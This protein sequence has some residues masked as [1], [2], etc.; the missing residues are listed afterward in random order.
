M[1]KIKLGDRPKS[2]SKELSI[3]MLDGTTGSIKVDFTYRSR[4][5]YA[6]FVDEHYAAITADAELAIAAE[7][8]RIEAEKESGAD[9]QA[10]ELN[11]RPMSEV[12]LAAKQMETQVKFILG[13]V[14][15][16]NL[17]IPFDREAV[18]ELVSELPLAASSII[19]SY[20]E[21]MVEG[22]LGN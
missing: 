19:Q 9:K 8:A 18:E 16:W 2:I 17:D 13:A 20:R 22:R 7:K 11:K 14:E 12:E 10:T 21:A 15:G 4:K 6:A 3:P 1:A 5:Q